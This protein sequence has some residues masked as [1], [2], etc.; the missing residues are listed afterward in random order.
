MKLKYSWNIFVTTK[1]TNDAYPGTM[2]VGVSI[3][4]GTVTKGK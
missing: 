4:V 1:A 3:Q 2:C